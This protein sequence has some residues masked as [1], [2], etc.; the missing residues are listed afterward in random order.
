MRVYLAGCPSDRN[1]VIDLLKEQK[2]S[3]LYQYKPF[4]LDSYY[5]ITQNTIDRFQD[6]GDFLLDSGAFTF[7]DNGKTADWEEYTIKYGQFVR[8]YN[9]SKFFELDIDA[10]VGY[11]EVLRLRSILEN[12]AG[13]RC[14]PVWHDNRGKD[15]FIKHC[16]E[17]PYVAIGGLVNNTKVFTNQVRK[18]F[19]WFINTAHRNGAKIHALGFTALEDLKK[20]HFDSVDSSRWITGNRFGIAFHFNGKDLKPYPKPQGKRIK[21]SQTLA[22]FNFTEWCKYQKYA[23]VH[24]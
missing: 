14:I 21:D 17:Y 10:I 15:E 6:F 4:I 9:I 23:E 1:R 13:M 22:Y 16:E 12:E 5:Y 19:P 24:L 11:E 8:K 20:Y 18:F 2:D 7:L 3:P